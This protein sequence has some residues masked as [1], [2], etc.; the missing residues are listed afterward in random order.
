MGLSVSQCSPSPLAAIPAQTQ[1]RPGRIAQA[2]A[3]NCGYW[4]KAI[5]LK[6]VPEHL[7]FRSLTAIVLWRRPAS[8]TPSAANFAAVL[9]NCHVRIA[10][11]E[12][13]NSEGAVASHAVRL[14]PPGRPRGPRRDALGLSHL[15][16]QTSRRIFLHYQDQPPFPC[17]AK[18]PLP[19][20][21]VKRGYC[22]VFIPYIY[23]LCNHSSSRPMRTG[24]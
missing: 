6:R 22:F 3:V 11:R 16:Y 5:A 20:R 15:T 23:Q 19:G 17:K 2:V 7:H 10:S 18:L 1:R 21:R 9:K 12:L 14:F 4:T 8:R 24:T 13:L